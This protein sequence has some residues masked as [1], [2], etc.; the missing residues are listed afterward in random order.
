[1]KPNL[2]ALAAVLC[3]GVSTMA[4]VYSGPTDSD[5][6]NSLVD[7]VEVA[8]QDLVAKISAADSAGVSTDY[9]ET[10]RITV[11][12]FKDIYVPWDRANPSAHHSIGRERFDPLYRNFQNTAGLAVPFDELADCLEIIDVAI[13][14]LQQQIDGEIVLIEAPD[15]S[16]GDYALN[17]A[18]YELDGQ[19]IIPSKIFW[20]H[21]NEDYW[22]AYGRMSGEYYGFSPCMT[23]P[24]SIHAWQL[25]NR[26]A[27]VADLT[28]QNAGPIEFW[29]ATVVPGNSHWSRTGYPDMF[30]AGS[31]FFNHYDIDHP[32]TRQ[33]ETFLFDNFLVQMVE[34][35]VNGGG[36]R[37]HLLNNEPRFPIRQG[38]S[39]SANNVS[40]H[41]FEKFATW[42]EDKYGSIANLNSIYGSAHADLATAAS[43][44]YVLNDGVSESLQGGPIW[45]DWCKFNNERVN[46][47]FVFLNDGVHSADPT[48]HTHIK[49]W[50]GGSIHRDYQDQGIDYEF[51]TKLVD[52][53][54]SDSQFVPLNLEFDNINS[55]WNTDWKSR[56]MF[57]WRQQ[58]VMMDFIKSIAPDKPYQDSEW[59]GIDGGR[60]LSFHNTEDYL[61]PALW[62]AASHGLS[63][64]NTWFLNREADGSKKS[65]NQ[66]FNGSFATQPIMMNAYGRIM[67]EINAHADTFASL[68]PELRNY[69]IYYSVDSAIQDRTY[70]D[71]MTDV[72]EALKLLNVPVGFT[73]PTE[74]VNVTDPTQ[75]LIVPRTEFISDVD[76]AAL[77]SFAIGGGKIVL[78]DSASC[79][80]KDELGFAR[81]GGHGF[82][83]FA[84]VSY[85]TS[86]FTMAADLEAA[87]AARKPGQP[88]QV[89]IRTTSGNA[90]YGVLSQ[91]FTDGSDGEVVLLVNASQQPRKVSLQLES[92]TATS[93]TNLINGQAHSSEFTMDPQDVLLLK[94][95]PFQSDNP[96]WDQFVADY[97]LSGIKTNNRDGDHLTDYGEYIFGGDPTNPADKGEPLS[98]D[99]ATGICTF[100]LRNDTSILAYVQSKSELTETRWA[101]VEKV[102]ITNNDGQM[103]RYDVFVGSPAETIYLRIAAGDTDL[104]IAPPPYKFILGD[105][106]SI[107]V[108]STGNGNFENEAGLTGTITLEAMANWHNIA[109]PETQTCGVDQNMGGSPEANSRGAYLFPSFTIANDSGYTISAAGELFEL[110]MAVLPVGNS[111]RYDGDELVVVS[112]FTTSTG[113]DADT[114]LGDITV[115]AT[116]KFPLTDWETH[117]D[118]SFYT[119]AAGDIGKTVYLAITLENPAGES[120]FPRVDVV[121]LEVNK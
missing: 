83:P 101:I 8:Y 116:T 86:T 66:T 103:T 96:N 63:A 89:G 117:T 59:H 4:G 20:Q 19:T 57:D 50:G 30:D 27:N 23:S 98:Y 87:L 46:D 48:G 114:I 52:V 28:A 53:A 42:L 112:L 71:Q 17:G 111:S 65:T 13:N 108:A 12:L 68:V 9:A 77:Q 82:T 113:V 26:T 58:G 72:Y 120:V 99:Y 38:N 80:I 118:S 45:Y 115:L 85:N 105:G 3:S 55:V 121:K 32:N 10:T 62:L 69:V 106:G 92:G 81:A 22:T 39:D 47:W 6:Y 91:Q 84:T 18:Y 44:N 34:P 51:L 43:A 54:G 21:E 14:E 29:H 79:F 61:R 2:I 70:S 95:A 78:V 36:V 49:I 16:V 107:G 94:T 88:L 56:Y 60:W 75:T 93:F 90:A 104:E 35:S 76:L 15:F 37:S 5:T 67:K 97:D 110:S 1:M 41:T 100:H 11:K 109:G 31:R 119:S 24:T 102:D 40:S 7:Q 64:I 33:W 73:T 74:L 25:S